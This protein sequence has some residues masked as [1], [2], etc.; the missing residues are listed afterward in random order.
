MHRMEEHQRPELAA[1]SRH[2]RVILHAP[3]F[4]GARPSVGRRF[5]PSPNRDKDDDESSND[6]VE[7]QVSVV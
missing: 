1:P 2:G 6:S 5:P 3:L 4:P 7:P